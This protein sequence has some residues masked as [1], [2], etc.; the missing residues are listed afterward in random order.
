MSGQWF[1]RLRVAKKIVVLYLTGVT[2][3]D[4][5]P[6]LLADG[7][8]GLMGQPGSYGMDEVFALACVGSLTARRFPTNG[9]KDPG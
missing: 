5:R 9:R 3:E 1:Y 7:R 2:S 4:L 8:I 6:A